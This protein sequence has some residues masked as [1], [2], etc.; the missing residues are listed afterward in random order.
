MAGTVQFTID[1]DGA[2]TVVELPLDKWQ[3][4]RKT[5]ADRY[6]FVNGGNERRLRSY[7]FL[8]ELDWVYLSSAD[9]ALL[10]QVMDALSVPDLRQEVRL[11][12]LNSIAYG[13]LVESA[14]EDLMM[15]SGQYYSKRP[16]TV[17]L[18]TKVKKTT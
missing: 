2:A 5:L 17:K 8:F 1:P 4:R 9:F 6:E 11:D 18:E 12:N 3:V 16:V 7:G 10:K 15:D 13:D 14:A